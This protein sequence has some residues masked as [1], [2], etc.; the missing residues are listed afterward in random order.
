MNPQ[1]MSPCLS[2]ER[3]VHVFC[4]HVFGASLLGCLAAIMHISNTELCSSFK[5]NIFLRSMSS[6]LI[7]STPSAQLFTSEIRKIIL[8][9]FLSLFPTS[10]P[11]IIKVYQFNL[12]DSTIQDYLLLS[13][14][15]PLPSAE[16]SSGL[17][18]TLL[19]G[20]PP[21]PSPHY[22]FSTKMLT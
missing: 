17:L 8:D 11:S 14:W 18:N 19:P 22:P 12:Q 21:G 5:S 9:F 6:F 20:F 1:F 2:W 15:Y 4:E 16:T 13:C 3:Q 10:N 7:N